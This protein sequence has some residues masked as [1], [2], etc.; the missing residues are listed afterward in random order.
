MTTI[1][2]SS[3]A[4]E[5]LAARHLAARARVAMEQSLNPEAAA[6]DVLRGPEGPE[7]RQG[8]RGERGEKG[9][10]GDRGQDGPRGL[11]GERGDE[12]PSGKAGP[13][14]LQGKQ[15]EPGENCSGEHTDKYGNKVPRGLFANIPTPGPTGPQ[16]PAGPAGSGGSA[17]VYHQATPSASWV[18]THAIGRL[19][20]VCLLD[21]T[22]GAV[23]ASDVTQ[24]VNQVSV[25]FPSPITGYAVLT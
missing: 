15:G 7:G 21:D 8:E 9:E 1:D 10:Q 24:I 16:G 2:R 23:F 4:R 6:A 12:G 5:R 14:G 13:R 18:I 25:A 22:T 20:G 11:T 19:V 3:E 17:T